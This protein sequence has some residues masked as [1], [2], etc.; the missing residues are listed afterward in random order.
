MSKGGT[1]QRGRAALA[2]RGRAFLA[3]LPKLPAGANA[4]LTAG[5]V[6]AIGVV[7]S[8][9]TGSQSSALWWVVL[10][11]LVIV[12]AGLAFA[13]SS[14]ASPVPPGFTEA[15]KEQAKAVRDQ[16]RASIKPILRLSSL[17]DAPYRQGQAGGEIAVRNGGKG[18]A[19]IT[20]ATIAPM[21][22]SRTDLDVFVDEQGYEEGHAWIGGCSP[23][24][25]VPDQHATVWF[26][27]AADPR[28]TDEPW[29]WGRL[30]RLLE[31]S[32]CEAKIDYQD[33]EGHQQAS[34]IVTIRRAPPAEGALARRYDVLNSKFDIC[35]E[36]IPIGIPEW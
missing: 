10:V 30:A 8:F 18:A 9:A 20:G 26:R 4:V 32:Q 13:A 25:A 7:T 31:A 36:L 22:V 24:Y 23:D 16:T 15:A 19:R 3:I 33:V 29:G 34:L 35:E 21:F 2:H 1:G 6:A 14:H 11:V 12:A 27:G 28:S 17:E 5:V